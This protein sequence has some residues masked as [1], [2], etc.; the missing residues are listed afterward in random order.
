MGFLF[1]IFRVITGASL[2]L[3]MSLWLPIIGINKI[4]TQ[5][6]CTIPSYFDALTRISNN[7]THL[8]MP[9]PSIWFN[10]DYETDPTN[11][12]NELIDDFN[13][14]AQDNHGLYIVILVHLIICITII[15]VVWRWINVKKK[16][17]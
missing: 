4:P 15:I 7:K 16:K 5:F 10:C 8:V 3:P 11:L 14:L 1:F 9:I 2:S 6:H 13:W 12:L 17:E